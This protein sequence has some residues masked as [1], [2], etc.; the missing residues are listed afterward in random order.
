[1]SLQHFVKVNG[2]SNLFW[3]WGGED[4]DM[5]NRIRFYKLIISRYPASIARYKMLHHKKVTETVKKDVETQRER[6][7]WLPPTARPNRT[8]TVSE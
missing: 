4:D 8:R 2:F 5:A 6:G 7:T 1:M 3:G